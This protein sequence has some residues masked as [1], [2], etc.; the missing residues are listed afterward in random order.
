MA[1]GL[2]ALLN[3]GICLLASGTM[4]SMLRGAGLAPSGTAHVKGRGCLL[5]GRNWEMRGIMFNR[6]MR[7]IMFK[8]EMRGIMF[9]RNVETREIVTYI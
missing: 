3:Q 6:E 9:K 8:R 7:G 5:R 2:S 1:P 4:R